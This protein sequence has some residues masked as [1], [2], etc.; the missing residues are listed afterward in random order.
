MAIH[1]D[2]AALNELREAVQTAGKDYKDKFARLTMLIEEITRG[3]IQ[4]DPATDLLNKF[5]A[6]KDV[7][8][9]VAKTIDDAEEFM[10]IQSESFKSMMN[11]LQSTMK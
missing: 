7:F 11:N 10:G 1:V 9:G 6:K 5:E 3:D 8:N 2:E 4:G